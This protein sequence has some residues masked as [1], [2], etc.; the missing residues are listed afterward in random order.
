VFP[1][2]ECE[3]CELMW[4]SDRHCFL[5]CEAAAEVWHE[6]GLW[7]VIEPMVDIA[8]LRRTGVEF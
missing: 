8:E 6:A 5:R 7:R 4:E 1:A 3:C 2:L